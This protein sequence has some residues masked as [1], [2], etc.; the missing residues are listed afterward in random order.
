MIAR[1]A[2]SIVIGSV[3]AVAL[4]YLM[5]VL[6]ATGKAAIS[7]DRSV[8]FVDFIKIEN[9]PEVNTRDRK[10]EKPDKPQ[11]PPPDAP[12][13]QMDAVE[14]GKTTINV[15]RPTVSADISISGTGLSQADGEYLPIV[16]VAP[17]YPRRAQSRGLE[18]YVIVE[19]TVTKA[20]TVKD[21]VVV[22]SSSSLFNSAAIKAAEKFKYKP[23]VI[24]GEAVEVYG[25]QNLIRFELE[26]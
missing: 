26:D 19:F 14:P 6:I 9:P 25:V 13:P 4:L 22:E 5:Q 1:Y 11:E 2:V 21:V 3:V 18:G 7:E 24:D 23:R 17:I 20:G 15:G 16:K 8:N 12:K 10:P